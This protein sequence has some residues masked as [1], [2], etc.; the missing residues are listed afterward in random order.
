MLTFIL[1]F[2]L[3][4]SSTS[5]THT[6]TNIQ[7]QAAVKLK[8]EPLVDGGLPDAGAAVVAKKTNQN[9]PDEAKEWF[10]HFHAYQKNRSG[11]LLTCSWEKACQLA[12]E[13]FGKVGK[14]TA[15]SGGNCTDTEAADR[16]GR[17][18]GHDGAALQR[19]AE[20]VRSLSGRVALCSTVHDVGAAEG[21][22]EDEVRIPA[23]RQL[24][25][26]IHE[27][28]GALATRRVATHCRRCMLQRKQVQREDC[29]V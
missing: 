16:R 15:F 28:S 22:R 19:L 7:K 18:K 2:A 25:Q 10:L 20:I 9:V 6:H 12:P 14:K 11:W 1:T 3:Q 23:Q 29:F 21:T 8:E 13:L 4:S 26:R 17:P 24:D 27:D 5:E